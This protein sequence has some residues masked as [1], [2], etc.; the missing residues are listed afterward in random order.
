MRRPWGALLLGALLC[1]H[2]KRRRPASGESLSLGPAAAELRSREPDGAGRARDPAPSVPAVA[3]RL[4]AGAG[5]TSSPS[6]EVLDGEWRTSSRG[7]GRGW[8]GLGQIRGAR[9]S[10]LAAL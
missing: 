10:A 9:A 4:R 1:A 2:G 6:S 3:L 7:P 5:S 8:A